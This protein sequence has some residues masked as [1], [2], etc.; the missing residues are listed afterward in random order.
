MIPDVCTCKRSTETRC[1]IR[2]TG[3]CF[4][5]LFSIFNQHPLYFIMRQ[6]VWFTDQTS[7]NFGFIQF[8]HSSALETRFVL[9][10]SS[11]KLGE[12]MLTFC[13]KKPCQKRKHV[14]TRGTS[15]QQDFY[16]ITYD[17]STVLRALHREKP[18]ASLQFPHK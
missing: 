8:P 5:Q 3:R 7:Q 11:L 6:T 13:F 1:K 14:R 10:K 9:Y 4:L 17:T 15:L 12:K 18:F 2:G 16:F